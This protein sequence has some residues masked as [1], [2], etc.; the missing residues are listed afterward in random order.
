VAT[1]NRNSDDD[2]CVSFGFYSPRHP[3]PVNYDTHTHT[4]THMHARNVSSKRRVATVIDYPSRFRRPV[5]SQAK[6]MYQNVRQCKRR[7]V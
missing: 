5:L 6:T 3:A 4:H 1:D 2:K 7:G